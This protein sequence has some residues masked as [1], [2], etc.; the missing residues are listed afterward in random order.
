MDTG[1]A[2]ATPPEIQAGIRAANVLRQSRDAID[3]IAQKVRD[4]TGE[5]AHRTAEAAGRMVESQRPAEIDALTRGRIEAARDVERHA[6]GRAERQEDG[7]R[8]QRDERSR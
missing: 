8:R 6:R 1:I 5:L 3:I 7:D 2:D 4:T